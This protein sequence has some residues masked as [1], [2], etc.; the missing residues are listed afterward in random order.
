M[1]TVNMLLLQ[2]GRIFFELE[3]EYYILSNRKS[4][5][6]LGEMFGSRKMEL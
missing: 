1:F 2:G 5:V 4:E 3:N 6:S